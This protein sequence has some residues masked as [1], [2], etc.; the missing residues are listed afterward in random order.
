MEVSFLQGTAANIPVYKNK[1]SAFNVTITSS[2]SLPLVD[3]V[4]LA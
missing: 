4:V 2:H 1:H 3:S